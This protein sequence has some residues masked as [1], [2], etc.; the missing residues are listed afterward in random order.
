MVD[1][2]LHHRAALTRLSPSPPP[3]LHA[4]LLAQQGWRAGED[5]D[6]LRLVVLRSSWASGSRPRRFTSCNL[7]HMVGN[8]CT[9]ETYFRR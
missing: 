9:L 4:V 8:I 6:Q 1:R 5:L 2:Q 7:L 3:G